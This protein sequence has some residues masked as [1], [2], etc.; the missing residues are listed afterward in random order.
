RRDLFEDDFVT[1]PK[2]PGK[3][4]EQFTRLLINVTLASMRRL[5]TGPIAIL[6]PLCGRGTTLSIAMMLGCNAAGV[7][8]ELKAVEAYAAYLRTSWR[9]QRL[10]HSLE[11]RP[12]GRGG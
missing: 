2:Y 12:V 5:T 8:A 3:T 7:E 9:R 10:Q 6:D 11:L 4:N 1:I